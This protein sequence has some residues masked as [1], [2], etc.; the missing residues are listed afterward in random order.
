MN[1]AKPQIGFGRVWH[2]RLRPVEHAFS[3]VFKGVRVRLLNKFFIC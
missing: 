1:I 3:H 2:R